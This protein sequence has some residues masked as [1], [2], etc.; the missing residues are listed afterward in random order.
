[1]DEKK[2]FQEGMEEKNDRMDV[3][4]D[5]PT[6]DVYGA[7]EA[8]ST[9]TFTGAVQNDASAQYRY[10]GS[11][12]HQ[13]PQPSEPWNYQ[14][15]QQNPTQS[16]WSYQQSQSNYGQ[17]YGQPNNGGNGGGYQGGYY[18]YQQ[19][20]SEPPKKKKSGKGTKVLV[21]ILCA[22]VLAGSAFGASIAGS[23][24]GYQKAEGNH[25]VMAE[26]GTID[27]TDAKELQNSQY[28][29]VADIVEDVSKS[30]ATIVTD[31]GYATGVIVAEDNDNVYIAT[32]Y[33]MLASTSNVRVI[34]GEDDETSYQPTLQGADSDTNLAIIKVAKS[35]IAEE[36]RNN[37]KVATLGDSTGM[38]LGDLA[39]V[40]SSPMGYY[41]TPS[42]GTISGL[43]RN[44][45]FSVSNQAITMDLIQTD[46]AVNT[47]GIL[48]N[49]R[50]EVIGFTLDMT[51]EDSEGIGFAIPTST[52]KGIIEE[53]IRNGFVEKPYMGFSGYDVMNFY[54]NNSSVSW[55]EYYKLP[56]G[57]LVSS[58][59]EG[60]PAAQAGL[61]VYDVI[62]SFNGNPI[63]DFSEMKE[64]LDECE[65]GQTVT[66]EVLRNYMNG[67]TPETVELTVT[68]Q[69]K[70]Q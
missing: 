54:P 53:L 38:V 48:V 47:S 2:E 16:N 29:S 26:G 15:A 58:V 57:V 30:L 13:D 18:G 35:D 64:W 20:Q 21:G 62:I 23:Y 49:G 34:F 45:S 51:I 67:G 28:S 41:N 9:D 32:V 10:T 8:K 50:G 36:Q 19:P 27:R 31:N 66:I 61:K 33:H 68:I 6:E 40:F 14:Q 11:Q 5:V 22:V 59:N 65:I 60:S 43:E 3:T 42:L 17:P 39:L 69:Q 37:L 52:A 4:A 44:V 25:V 24:F 46:A 56:M 55:A 1:M 7:Q 12:I 63:N 70:P